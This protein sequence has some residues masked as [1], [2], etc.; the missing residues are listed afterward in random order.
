MTSKP[1]AGACRS[2]PSP[3][4]PRAPLRTMK[5]PAVSGYGGGIAF[6]KRVR[7]ANDR[8]RAVWGEDDVARIADDNTAVSDLQFNPGL[9]VKP[10]GI[11]LV[12]VVVVLTKTDAIPGICPR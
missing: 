3:S 1:K 9:L 4:P 12:D 6:D 7:P 5:T 11:D 10:E 2:C 8:D